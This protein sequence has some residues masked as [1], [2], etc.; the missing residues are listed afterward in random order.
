MSTLTPE[1]QAQLAKLATDLANNP[2]TRRQFVGLVKEIDPSKRFPDVE[3]DEM[4]EAIEK[5]FEERDQAEEMKRVQRKLAKQ[6]AALEGRYGEDDIKEIEKFMEQKGYTDYED[7]AIIYGAKIKPATPTYDVK[8]HT[9][10]MPKI[11]MKDMGNLPQRRRSSLMS[12]I[13]EVQRNRKG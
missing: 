10:E 1:A 6:R 13:D 9:W 5:K 11:D 8:D 7:A 3:S 4:R 2:K 12:A